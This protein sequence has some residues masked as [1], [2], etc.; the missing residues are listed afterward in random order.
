[1]CNINLKND[2]TMKQIIFILISILCL[3]VFASDYVT[4][5]LKYSNNNYTLV[6]RSDNDYEYR[7]IY[8][9]LGNKQKAIDYLDKLINTIK[10]AEDMASIKVGKY[11]TTL[12]KTLE[13][14]KLVY[15]SSIKWN[16]DMLPDINDYYK[17]LFP[18]P[19][20]YTAGTYRIRLS[21]IVKAYEK[22]K[23]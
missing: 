7:A 16:S 19:S 11:N 18:N 12:F 23:N 10:S 21:E 14:Y 20:L 3:D 13:T 2:K 4:T 9:K 6:V 1:M 5:N 22:I 17:L 15:E 8:I